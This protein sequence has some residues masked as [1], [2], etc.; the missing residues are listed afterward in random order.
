MSKSSIEWTDD[1]WNPVSG[2]TRVSAGC[3]PMLGSRYALTRIVVAVLR[4]RTSETLRRIHMR[5]RLWDSIRR[6]FDSHLAH[7]EPA[8]DAQWTEAPLD[9]RAGYLACFRSCDAPVHPL[10]VGDRAFQKL[11]ACAH[12]HTRE[13]QPSSARAASRVRNHC[14]QLFG[15]LSKTDFF[16]P[17]MSYPLRN[18]IPQPDSVGVNYGE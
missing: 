8:C 17:R 3:D 7:R 9:F 5:M 6:A 4:G 1:T 10:Q 16:H 13:N 15:H 12:R 11:L 14:S 2:C 18:S